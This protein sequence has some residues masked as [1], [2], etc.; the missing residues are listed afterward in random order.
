M[1]NREILQDLLVEPEKAAQAALED[2]PGLLG[3][4]DG[5]RGA[6]WLRQ[7]SAGVSGRA[8]EE[9]DFLLT[10]AETAQR[11]KV[12]ED[13]IYRNANKFPFTVRLGPN[14]LRFSSK[15]IEKYIKLRGGK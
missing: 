1:N 10:A 4:L 3:D 9:P 7:T 11:L 6:L 15:G 13:H 2:V 8:S 5:L 14:Q 12:S